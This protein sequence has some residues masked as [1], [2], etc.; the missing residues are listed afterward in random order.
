MCQNWLF[1]IEETMQRVKYVKITETKYCSAG[2]IPTISK[3]D[4]RIYYDLADNSWTI[5]SANGSVLHATGKAT[6]KHKVLVAIRKELNKYGSPYSV[7]KR[8]DRLSPEQRKLVELT[9]KTKERSSEVRRLTK[10][11]PQEA[12]ELVDKINKEIA[13]IKAIKKDF[14]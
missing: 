5:T 10:L 12:E 14:I 8:K 6:S 3:G 13:N 9:R 11:S 4:I 1:F 2:I 7:E